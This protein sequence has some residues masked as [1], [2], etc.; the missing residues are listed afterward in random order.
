MSIASEITRLYDAK[1]GIIQ[2]ITDKG[3]TVP[4]GAKLDDMAAL[5][6]SISGGGATLS[7]KRVDSV[8]GNFIVDDNGYIGLRLNDYFPHDGGTFL[9][10]YAVVVSGADFSSAGLGQVTFLTPGV[11]S[12]GGRTY[13]TV[14]IG[15]KIWMTENLD[16]RTDGITI[17]PPGNPTTPA[18]WYYNNDPE[19]YG[20][21]GNKY[22]LLYNWYAVKYLVDNVADITP[23]WHVPTKSELDALATAVGGSSTAGTKLKSTTGWS[24]GNGDGSYGFAAFPAGGRSSGSFV[25]LGSKANFWT[26]TEYSSSDAYRRH[27]GTD[28]SMHSDNRSKANA[29]SV[30][31]VKDAQ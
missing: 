14:N 18:A 26:A 19:T 20:E 30:R 7:V 17:G 25:D 16:L 8:Q 10:N 27:F 22:G 2:A 9:D 13:S 28:A 23:G 24:S 3:V 1:G 11:D 31:L 15:G 21:N 5:I 12:I 29:Y 4:S 6:E